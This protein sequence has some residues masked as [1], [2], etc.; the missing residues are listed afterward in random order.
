VINAHAAFGHHLFKIAVADPV[1]AIPANCPQH[2]LTA[3]MTAFECTHEIN[4]LL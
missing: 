3:E 4:N 2:D 1:P